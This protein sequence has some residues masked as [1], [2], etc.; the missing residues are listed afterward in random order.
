MNKFS[1]VQNFIC[2]IPE[3]LEI[4]RKNTPKVA[5]VWGDYEY[6]VNFN[7]DCLPPINSKYTADKGLASFKAP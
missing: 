6:F 4:I 5:E 2:N 3:R 1:V 7:F